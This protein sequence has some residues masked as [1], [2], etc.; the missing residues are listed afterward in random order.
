MYGHNKALTLREF[1]EE[2]KTAPDTPKNEKHCE[3]ALPLLR[4]VE[5]PRFCGNGKPN[6]KP[7]A[8]DSKYCTNPHG[9]FLDL[10]DYMQDPLVN[11]LFLPDK[12]VFS[13]LGSI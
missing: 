5:T 9:N 7:T 6:L 13:Y 3:T 8:A 2:K 10:R 1:R 4:C 11:S 12:P